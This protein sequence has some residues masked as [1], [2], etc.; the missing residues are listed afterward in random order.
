LRHYWR[1]ARGSR[2]LLAVIVASM[3]IDGVLQAG[4]IGYLKVMIDGL[5]ADPSGFVKNGLLALRRN[6]G[7]VIWPS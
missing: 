3:V 2:W 7:K 1:Q 6:A 4:L 5:L